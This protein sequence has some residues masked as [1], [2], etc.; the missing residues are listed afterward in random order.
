MALIYFNFYN[1]WDFNLATAVISGQYI[2][3][4]IFGVNRISFLQLH[5]FYVIWW[6][7][8]NEFDYAVFIIK[9]YTGFTK[10]F[11]EYNPKNRG[12]NGHLTTL[13]KR[14][15]GKKFKFDLY[16][17][18][19]LFAIGIEIIGQLLYMSQLLRNYRFCETKIK[20][21]AFF[22]QIRSK[23]KFSNPI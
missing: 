15:Y 9:K 8:E 10:L 19:F 12:T 6:Y 7:R 23:G 17:I 14:P 11:I 2:Y 20:K 5:P 1:A 4:Y 3:F 13:I 21:I 16:N 18:I 22:W